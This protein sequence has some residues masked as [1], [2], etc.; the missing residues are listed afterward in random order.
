L[1]IEQIE[2]EASSILL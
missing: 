2:Q 1:K